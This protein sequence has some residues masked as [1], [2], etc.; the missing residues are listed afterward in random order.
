MLRTMLALMMLMPLGARAA[1]DFIA[2]GSPQT[3]GQNGAI[4][5]SDPSH[6]VPAPRGAMQTLGLPT[7][8]EVSEPMGARLS[9]DEA[10]RRIERAGYRRVVDLVEDASG[11]WRGQ[12][13]KA[14]KTTA[15]NCTG[16]GE[17]TEG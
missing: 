16:K 13:Q 9:R 15:I 14:G 6:P 10:K 3:V 7:K 17:I 5:G 11:V 12:A 1:T 2:P 8:P 4:L